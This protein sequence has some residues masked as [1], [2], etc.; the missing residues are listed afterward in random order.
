[1]ALR[2][3][4][5]AEDVAHISMGLDYHRRL[6]LLFS[7]QNEKDNKRRAASIRKAEDH[8]QLATSYIELF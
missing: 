5:V 7:A 4:D 3:A 6:N 2:Y 1:L 8:L